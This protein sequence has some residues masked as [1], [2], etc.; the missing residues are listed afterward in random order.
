MLLAA[1]GA[2]LISQG[3]SSGDHQQ[4]AAAPPSALRE[5]FRAPQAAPVRVSAGYE[6][7]LISGLGGAEIELV[8]IEQGDLAVS[9]RVID[10]RAGVPCLS[11]TSAAIP[12]AARA[13]SDSSEEI[14]N[15]VKKIAEPVTATAGWKFVEVASPLDLPS[16]GSDNVICSPSTA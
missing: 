16:S 2:V 5:F 14:S 1:L 3:A 7:E 9:H 13:F 4:S 15:Q 11:A 12:K 10:L 6:S 8:K